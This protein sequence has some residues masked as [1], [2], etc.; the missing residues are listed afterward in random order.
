MKIFLL[1]YDRRLHRLTRV[2]EFEQARRQE[3]MDARYEA[4]LS[5][6]RAGRDEEIVILEASSL[7]ALKRTHGS[8][9]FTAK[10]FGERFLREAS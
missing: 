8:Y 4:E 1:I 3:A 10:E 2:S 7:D 6:M 9:F 5:A